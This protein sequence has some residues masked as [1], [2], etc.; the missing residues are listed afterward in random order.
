MAGTQHAWGVRV[1]TVAPTQ[2]DISRLVT[3][4]QGVDCKRI[5][6][7]LKIATSLSPLVVP[8]SSVDLT[9][10]SSALTPAR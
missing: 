7:D 6:S 10:I 9:P 3:R 1:K 2:L 8:L 5:A 4:V